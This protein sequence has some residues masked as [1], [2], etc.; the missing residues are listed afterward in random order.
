MTYSSKTSEA[1]LWKWLRAKTL[2]LRDLHL[3]RVE[4]SCGSG[5][6]DVE[7]CWASHDFKIELK[8]CARPSRDATELDL[9]HLTTEQCMWLRRRVS[10]GGRAFVLVRVGCNRDA[11]HYLVPGGGRPFEMRNG[12]LEAKLAT[13]S[14]CE[15]LADAEQLV[16]GAAMWQPPRNWE[17]SISIRASS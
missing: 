14:L 15:P 8:T 2:R 5:Y 16:T 17:R 7:G 6:P 12:L 10:V 3:C 1:S 4:N 11:R 13:Y 9:G